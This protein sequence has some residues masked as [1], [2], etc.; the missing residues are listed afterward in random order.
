MFTPKIGEDEPILT[1]ICFKW[2]GSTTNQLCVFFVGDVFMDSIPMGFVSIF[3]H[4]LGNNMFGCLSNRHFQANLS[5]LQM[6]FAGKCYLDTN[7][8]DGISGS[9]GW[10]S[11]TRIRSSWSNTDRCKSCF[12]RTW[13]DDCTVYSMYCASC[14][15]QLKTDDCGS[16]TPKFKSNGWLYDDCTP[17]KVAWKR[18]FGWRSSIDQENPPS[19]KAWIK[20][21]VFYFSTFH[22]PII[23]V[24]FAS[25]TRIW[26]TFAW[27]WNWP[28]P[29][30]VL[31]HKTLYI[32]KTQGDL[33]VASPS[34]APFVLF[35]FNF[36]PWKRLK[37]RKDNIQVD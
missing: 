28:V 20:L 18:P 32:G 21:D 33:H 19:S 7:K 16:F 34:F 17:P 22:H 31:P 1:I 9:S 11:A 4:P 12:K 24:F 10:L 6:F 27:S 15:D 2:V 8:N 23:T 36:C 5:F 26:T 13:M 35:L 37:K 25:L 29:K 30:G 14:L 3:D